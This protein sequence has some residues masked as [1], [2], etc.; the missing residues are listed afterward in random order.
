MNWY[1]VRSE[2]DGKP[3]WV[4]STKAPDDPAKPDKLQVAK[5]TMEGSII[6]DPK[7]FQPGDLVEVTHQPPIEPGDC[8]PFEEIL[9]MLKDVPVQPFKPSVFFNQHAPGGM[10]EVVWKDVGYYVTYPESHNKYHLALC[11]SF[12][13][14]EI[15]GVKIED[16]ANLK[17]RANPDQ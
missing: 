17:L 10:L 4:K 7:D 12:E 14:D 8:I 1:Y 9:A 11:K 3:I 6:L 2:V 16:I 13:D 5:E 15:V